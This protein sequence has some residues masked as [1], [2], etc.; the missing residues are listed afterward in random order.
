[1]SRL[2]KLSVLVLAIALVMFISGWILEENYS[3]PQ[4]RSVAVS[5]ETF[6]LATNQTTYRSVPLDASG[7]YSLYV[8]VP[9]DS[10]TVFSAA[11]SNQSLQDWLCGNYNVSWAGTEDHGNYGSYRM[12]FWRV[13]NDSSDVANVVFWNPETVTQQV[14]FEVSRDW[15]ESNPVGY[16]AGIALMAAGVLGFLTVPAVWTVKNRAKVVTFKWT[17]K[18]AISLLIAL[19]LLG[20]GSGRQTLFRIHCRDKKRFQRAS[21][22]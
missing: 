7:D 1:M 5:S 2:G 18:K 6:P 9:K 21:Y 14:N 10:G 11:I 4:A 13:A 19:V 8:S 15:Y 3:G 22:L 20:E 12:D 17:G 16:Y